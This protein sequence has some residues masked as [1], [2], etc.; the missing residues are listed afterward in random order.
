PFELTGD[1]SAALQ[2]IWRLMQGHAP[3]GLLLQG[4][5]AT[6]KTAVAWCSAMAAMAAGWQVAFLA[7]TE[8]LSEQH[9]RCVQQLCRSMQA[10]AV[11]LTASSEDRAGVEQT[12]RAGEPCM[13]FGT[14]A[15]FSDATG[16]SNLGLVI[17]DEQHRF[18]VDQRARLIRK[19]D[20]PHVLYMTATPI[21]RTLTLTLFGDLDLAVLRQ[22]PPGHRP[23]PAFYLPPTEWPR[24]LKI[25]GRRVARGEQVFVVCSKIGADG[26]KGGAVRLQREVAGH[27]DC[28]LVHGQMDSKERQTNL[29]GFRGGEFPVLVGTTVLEVGVDVPAATLMVVVGCDR[30]GLATLHQLRGRVGRGTR[31]GLCILTGTASARTRAVCRSVDGFALAEQDLVLR[32]SGELTGH[33]QSGLS[34]LRALDPVADLDLLSEVRD[35]VRLEDDT[36]TAVEGY[37]GE[38]HA[39]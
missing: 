34:E 1:Q 30:F 7:P 32:G 2:K 23:A 29:D 31:R 33:R 15:L 6:G 17:I 21:P 35:L 36:V 4:D 3:M 24:V 38:N 12:L 9:Y 18:G 22:R 14:H 28:R 37:A 10:S 39:G 16:F 25:I 13:V 11:L 20:N 8:L 27:F 5:V 19:G 26:E